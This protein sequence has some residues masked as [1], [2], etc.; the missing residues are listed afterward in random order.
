MW[1]I[2]GTPCI[3]V[4]NI[5]FIVDACRADPNTFLLAHLPSLFTD[6]ED[7]TNAPEVEL[8]TGLRAV[9]NVFLSS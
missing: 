2:H 8:L 6:D 9:H 7:T 4:T 5:L 1:H 3:L